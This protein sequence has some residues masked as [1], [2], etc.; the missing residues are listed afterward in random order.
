MTWGFAGF[1]DW[2][3]AAKKIMIIVR[4]MVDRFIDISPI[5]DASGRAR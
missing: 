2:Q 3:L 5:Q 1:R 4:S